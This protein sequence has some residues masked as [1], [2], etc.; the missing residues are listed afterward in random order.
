M[1]MYSLNTPH[2]LHAAAYDLVLA[3]RSSLIIWLVSF[4][5]EG[6]LT[7]GEAVW[8]A[9]RSSHRFIA[10]HDGFARSPPT[11][12]VRRDRIL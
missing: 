3:R 5:Y 11:Y 9:S 7:I 4:R 8:M 6:T 12:R 1:Q 10:L 2:M